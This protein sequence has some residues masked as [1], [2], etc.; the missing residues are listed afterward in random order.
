MCFDVSWNIT[1]YLQFTWNC[2]GNIGGEY[3]WLPL[4]HSCV[5]C[6]QAWPV[7]VL[8]PS[9]GTPAHICSPDSPFLLS[10]MY[11]HTHTHPHAHTL[12]PRLLL[13]ESSVAQ[14]TFL[15]Q[16][17]HSLTISIPRSLTHS[18][19]CCVRLPQLH[20]KSVTLPF[21]FIDCLPD[22]GCPSRREEDGNKVWVELHSLKG[23]TCCSQ[24]RAQ[25]FLFFFFQEAC[26]FRVRLCYNAGELNYELNVERRDFCSLSEFILRNSYRC[27]GL[28]QFSGEERKAPQA[29]NSSIVAPRGRGGHPF[30]PLLQEVSAHQQLYTL[31]V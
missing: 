4:S 22:W 30:G 21:S 3:Y 28:R 2:M 27:S 6:A 9:A 19:T 13:R 16:H 7:L 5:V 20:T 15:H 29:S 1:C 18:H 10:L 17:P 26:V 31:C 8:P 11:T 12:A 23:N 25:R 24:I 14:S